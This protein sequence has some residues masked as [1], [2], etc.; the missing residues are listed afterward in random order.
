Q[1]L[2]GDERVRA[3]RAGVDLIV[4]QVV[5]LQHVH[6]ADRDRT[7][8]L[9][10]RLT[11]E[12]DRLTRTIQIRRFQQVFDVRDA[13]AVEDRSR[14]RNALGQVLGQFDQLFVALRQRGVGAVDLGQTRHQG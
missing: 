13:R 14:E 7:L 9:L 6:I 8:E 2:L 4:Y 3:D 12:Q 11:V 1:R 10:A 5:Q